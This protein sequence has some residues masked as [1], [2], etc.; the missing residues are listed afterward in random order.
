MR[1]PSGT[2]A[3]IENHLVPPR[4]SEAFGTFSA[5]TGLRPCSPLTVFSVPQLKSEQI[6]RPFNEGHEGRIG[7][8]QERP[9]EML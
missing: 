4:G 8:A 5:R 1:F 9:R 2:S 3:C 7:H 6:L